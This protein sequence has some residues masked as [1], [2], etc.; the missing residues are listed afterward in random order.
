MTQRSKWKNSQAQRYLAYKERIG[1]EARKARIQRIMG[2]VEVQAS[3][4]LYG[5]REP[6]AD[7]LAKAF[8]DGLNNIAWDDDRQVRKLSIEK[9]RVIHREEERTEIQ[10]REMEP[11][12][13][14]E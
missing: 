1:W 3:A 6:D 9:I 2:S 11:E 14:R 10:I 5:K 13:E 7:N 4:Y 12:G 8:L